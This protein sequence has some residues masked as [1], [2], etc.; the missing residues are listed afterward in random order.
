MSDDRAIKEATQVMEKPEK[1]HSKNGQN[2]AKS[3]EADSIYFKVALP[4]QIVKRDGRIVPFEID[5]IE[6]ALRRCFV[7]LDK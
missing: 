1:R 6:D 7:S 2:G 5:L 4:Q 3:F